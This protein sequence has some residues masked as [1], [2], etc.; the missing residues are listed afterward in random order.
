MPVSSLRLPTLAFLLLMLPGIPG[1]TV[2]VRAQGESCPYFFRD[3]LLWMDGSAESLLQWQMVDPSDGGAWRRDTLDLAGMLNPGEGEWLYVSEADTN[4]IGKAE[5]LSPELPETAQ[6]ND[7]T[8]S[9][10]LALETFEGNGIAYVELRQDDEWIRIFEVADDYYGKVRI[11]LGDFAGKPMQFRF[12]FDDEGEWSWGMGLDE[13][14]L[15]GRKAECGDG[16]CEP[17]EDCPGDCTFPEVAPGWIEPG[18]DLKGNQVNYSRFARGDRC[19]DCTQEVELGFSFTFFGQSYSTAYINSNGNLSLGQ[20]NLAYTPAPFC[21]TGPAM[22][23][24]F[25]ADVDLS[26]GGEIWYYTDPEKHFLI[27]SWLQVGYYG[28]DSNAAEQHN[29]FQLI[30]TDGTLRA[31]GQTA[32]PAGVNAIFS[33]GAMNWTTG[34]GSGGRNG[35]G[36]SAAN[37]GLNRGDGENCDDYGMFDRPGRAYYGSSLDLGCPPNEVNA[38]EGQTLLFNATE[39][40][41]APPTLALRL[42]GEALAQGHVLTWETFAPDSWELFLVE[43]ARDTLLPQELITLP[44]EEAPALSLGVF[45]ME[46]PRPQLKPWY[47]ITGL[48]MNGTLVMSNWVSLAD[49]TAGDFQLLFIG[50][51]PTDGPFTAKVNI[52]QAGQLAW[53]LTSMA[54]QVLSQG[55]WEASAGTLQESVS[56]EGLPTGTYVFTVRS[57]DTIQYR[58]VV[59]L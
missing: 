2:Q 26:K 29:T 5:L 47:R 43:A 13:I 32:I 3:S 51:N 11:Q 1:L 28:A 21:Q 8:L 39:G 54:G 58:Y 48:S 42:N 20:P 6:L 38:L 57:K 40:D 7:L 17:S 9:F 14:L 33:Y 46:I 16:I 37:V 25:F 27:V 23:A 55:T 30:L 22:I 4:H 35:F 31:V 52:H 19:D 53:Q 10:Y 41:Y 24:P 12:V 34:D 18:T 50:P 59:K 45:S 44:A 49:E 36:G 56:V 15:T